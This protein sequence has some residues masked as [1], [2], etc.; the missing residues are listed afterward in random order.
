LKNGSMEL[1]KLLHDAKVPFALQ[2]GHESYV[3]KTRVVLWEAGVAVGH[4]LPAEVALRALTI[5]AAKL[6][7]I[8]ARTGTLEVGKDADLALFDGDP[9]EYATHCVGTVIDGVQY[10][11]GPR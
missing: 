6:L 2:S 4:G 8:A 10:L 5:D 9:F 7:G 11:G 3:P 1:A